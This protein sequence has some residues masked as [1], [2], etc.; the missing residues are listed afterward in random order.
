MAGKRKPKATW[1]QAVAQAK[2]KA[3]AP[4]VP[5]VDEVP[6]DRF[7]FGCCQQCGDGRHVRHFYK[8]RVLHRECRIC[9][10]IIIL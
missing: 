7:P 2:E 3:E 9:G 1:G 10:N 4:L 5:L 6:P 8:D